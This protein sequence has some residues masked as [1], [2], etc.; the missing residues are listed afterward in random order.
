VIDVDVC[1]A[2]VLRVRWRDNVFVPGILL[3][4]RQ[5]WIASRA[6]DRRP[7]PACIPP[8]RCRHRLR[9]PAMRCRH[10]RR[11]FYA[12][13]FCRL[14]ALPGRTATLKSI[15]GASFFWQPPLPVAASPLSAAGRRFVVDE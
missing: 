15:Y 11:T 5:G 7:S 12:A 1:A 6:W 2:L 4:Y 9:L 14:A 10:L 13:C 8:R 3:A